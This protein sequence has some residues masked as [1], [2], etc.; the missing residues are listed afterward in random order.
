MKNWTRRH[1]LIAGIALILLTNA[2]A[3]L[4]VAWN[5]SGD[6]DKVLT[7]TQREL[8]LPYWTMNHENSGISLHIHWR[9][10]SGEKTAGYAYYG[11]GTADWLDQAKM[12]SLGFDPAPASA[13][14]DYRWSNRQLGK[15]VLAVQCSRRANGID[16]RGT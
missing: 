6:P 3:L 9:V 7:L 12:A 4:G 8:Q 10:Y 1:T 15:E 2:V 16:A 5:R 13:A 11:G 14:H